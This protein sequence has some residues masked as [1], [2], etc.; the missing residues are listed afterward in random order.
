MLGLTS[1]VILWHEWRSTF[2]LTNTLRR[3]VTAPF[4][5][6]TFRDFFIADQIMSIIIVLYDIEFT[7]CFFAYDAWSGSSTF[8]KKKKKVDSRVIHP[9]V[10]DWADH[11]D[12]VHSMDF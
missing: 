1:L 9:S 5:T 2:W 3:I 4:S 6:V 10:T 11:T 12:L 8:L 7:I